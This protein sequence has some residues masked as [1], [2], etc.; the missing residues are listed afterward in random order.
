MS[1]YIEAGDT[2]TNKKLWELKIYDIKKSARN[3]RLN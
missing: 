3:T 1:G 2:R